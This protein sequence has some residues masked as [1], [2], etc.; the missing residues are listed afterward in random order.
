MHF[1][2]HISTPHSTHRNSRINYS[3]QPRAQKKFSNRRLK[4]PWQ[5]SKHISYKDR[6]KPRSTKWQ[7]SRNPK[8]SPCNPP[9]TDT[10]TYQAPLAAGS[11]NK[12]DHRHLR[13]SEKP[14]LKNGTP[15]SHRIVT[16]ER[17]Q[18]FPQRN[19]SREDHSWPGD[20]ATVAGEGFVCRANRAIRAS[21]RSRRNVEE[22]TVGSSSGGRAAASLF[23]LRPQRNMYSF[24]N[25]EGER[26]RVA[27]PR[28]RA[29]TVADESISPWYLHLYELHAR[30][31]TCT[32]RC[33][34]VV[35]AGLSPGDPVTRVHR[36][37]AVLRGTYH[38][39]CFLPGHR[40]SRAIWKVFLF[41]FF[42]FSARRS[43]VFDGVYLWLILL[44]LLFV[45]ISMHFHTWKNFK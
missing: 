20:N 7:C 29:L 33:A 18:R 13:S 35:G 17:L 30:G 11:L 22:D 21:R 3:C 14:C 39:L 32:G 23:I 36:C 42:F 10:F 45:F 43:I 15:S 37:I 24:A 26:A 16:M 1:K 25:G 5:L 9:T 27:L 31:R 19:P 4:E 12:Y 28:D 38:C 6:P 8:Y 44:V 2:C 40:C 34:E 41:S